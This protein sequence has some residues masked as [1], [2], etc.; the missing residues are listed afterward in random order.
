MSL[1]SYKSSFGV[2][3]SSAKQL[4]IASPSKPK[5]QSNPSD[6]FVEFETFRAQI[7]KEYNEKMIQ[8]RSSTLQDELIKLKSSN[9]TNNSTINSIKGLNSKSNIYSTLPLKSMNKENID[10]GSFLENNAKKAPIQIEN[11]KKSLKELSA[12][13]QEKPK[14]SLISSLHFGRESTGSSVRGSELKRTND[15][16]SLLSTFENSRSKSNLDSGIYRFGTTGAFAELE[17]RAKLMIPSPTKRT[18]A[19]SLL[20]TFESS[21]KKI[22]NDS[23]I[24]NGSRGFANK[25]EEKK[26]LMKVLDLQDNLIDLNDQ[27]FNE[28]S[29]Q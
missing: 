21:S 4:P 15:F 6:L 20:N 5:T 10:N 22:R 8:G 17:N 16:K 1:S 29:N 9:I 12:K 27:E 13:K 24:M 23:D 19:E 28:C 2:R 7:K 26:T 25:W 3:P 14:D 18:K 11:L